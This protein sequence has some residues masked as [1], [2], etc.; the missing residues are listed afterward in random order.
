MGNPKCFVKTRDRHWAGFFLGIGSEIL[1]SG[2][3]VELGRKSLG[4]ATKPNADPW[5]KLIKFVSTRARHLDDFTELL[6]AKRGILVGETS[7]FL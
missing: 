3:W 5:L 4:C 7:V 6:S 1:D 2:F